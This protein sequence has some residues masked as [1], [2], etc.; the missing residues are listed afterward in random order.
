[1]TSFIRDLDND[2]CCIE[3]DHLQR[4]QLDFID[5]VANVIMHWA[6]CTH[7]GNLVWFKAQR[8]GNRFALRAVYHYQTAPVEHAA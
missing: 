4:E 3:P 1:M 7:L 5:C 8:R 2:T 6:L